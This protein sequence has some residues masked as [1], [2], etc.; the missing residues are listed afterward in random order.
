MRKAQGFT[1]VEVI[2]VVI[3]LL[4][5]GLIFW[6][7]KVVISGKDRDLERKTA[8]NAMSYALD[9]VYYA[10]NHYYPENLTDK[11]FTVV[12]PSLMKDPDGRLETRIL[13]TATSRQI[14]RADNARTILFE[15]N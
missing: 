3:V 2:F 4:A 9:N 7:Q 12:D 10:K 8:I 1:V 15:H 6:H 14:V 13:T 5:A 11:T